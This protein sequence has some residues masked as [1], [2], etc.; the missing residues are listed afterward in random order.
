MK[1][2]PLYIIW[3]NKINIGFSIIDEQHRGIV[4]TLNSLHYFIQLGHGLEALDPTLKIMKQYIGFHMKTEE[5]ILDSCYYPHIDQH[6]GMQKKII[7]DFNIISRE[8]LAYN[9]S[10]LLLKFIKNWWVKHI[11]ED[12]KKYNE[13]LKVHFN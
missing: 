11:N 1:N 12:H 6:V 4:A 7:S 5:T 3:N 10:E 8:A 9:D 2:P 13:Y